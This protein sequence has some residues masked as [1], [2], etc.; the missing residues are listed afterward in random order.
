[1]KLYSREYYYKH[2][3]DYVIVEILDTKYPSYLRYSEL[4]KEINSGLS[5]KVSPATLSF[6][7]SELS[8]FRNVLDKRKEKNRHTS[9]S[10]T[11]K[12]KDEL[13]I[14]KRKYPTTF[15]KETLSLRNFS[16]STSIELEWGIPADED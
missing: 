9:Y 11:K 8:F 15:A 14:Q 4:E 5:R 16:R 3:L 12:F 7:L 10:L 2:E 6:H 13:D 1:M